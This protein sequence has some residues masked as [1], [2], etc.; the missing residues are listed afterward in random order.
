MLRKLKKGEKVSEISSFIE[1]F[2]KIYPDLMVLDR[3]DEFERIKLAGKVE[4]LQEMRDKLGRNSQA[5]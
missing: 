2:E 3:K 5:D 4:L 1:S